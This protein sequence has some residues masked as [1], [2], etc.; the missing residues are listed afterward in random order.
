MGTECDD[1]PRLAL[2]SAFVSFSNIYL[3][4]LLT[5]LRDLRD[6]AVRLMRLSTMLRR[7]LVRLLPKN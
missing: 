7:Y 6:L 4:R 3:N 5:Q 1:L 2:Y